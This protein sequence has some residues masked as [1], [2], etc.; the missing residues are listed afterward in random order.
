MTLPQWPQHPDAPIPAHYQALIFDCDGTLVDT[1]P[2]HYRAWCKALAPHNLQF[3]E[4]QFYALAGAT[5]PAV[6]ALLAK[7]QNIQV[8]PAAIAHHKEN[9]YQASLR[10]L[11]PIPSVVN[12]AKRE[13]GRRKLA[14][15]SGGRQ[16]NVRESL[17]VIGL[18]HLFQVIV[19]QEDV[20]HGKP[21][22]DLFLKAAELLHVPPDACIVYEDGDLGI[23]AAHHAGMAAI[24][25]RPWYRPQPLHS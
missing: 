6:V 15:A 1:M 22:P 21:A 7:E 4:D 8:D 14:I 5:A 3:P 18:D 11:D 19:A 17:A 10:D 23:Q 13:F 24:D 25:V 9:L 2:V 20:T 16:A 12:I